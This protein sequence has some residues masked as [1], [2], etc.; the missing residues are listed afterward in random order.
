MGN[1]D[2]SQQKIVLDYNPAN[3]K[4][5]ETLIID[6]LK[7]YY[8][9]EIVR[10]GNIFLVIDLEYEK[11]RE[12]IKQQLIEKFPNI[13]LLDL[14]NVRLRIQ[15]VSKKNQYFL[16]QKKDLLKD[17]RMNEI[18]FRNNLT[19][20]VKLEQLLEQ[21]KNLLNKLE[22]SEKQEAAIKKRLELINN[23][24]S[25]IQWSKELDQQKRIQ[26]IKTN[27][28]KVLTQ[29]KDNPPVLESVDK[30]A[31]QWLKAL[32]QQQRIGQIKK[33]LAPVLDEINQLP[34]KNQTVMDQQTKRI[35]TIK[36]N[37]SNVLRDIKKFNINTLNLVN[38]YGA[39][40][41]LHQLQN[42]SIDSQ[43]VEQTIPQSM[44]QESQ[45]DLQGISQL[46]EQAQSAAQKKQAVQQLK[47]FI[48][49]SQQDTQ[50]LQ[51]IAQLFQQAQT[52]GQEQSKF[53]K[54]NP[55]CVKWEYTKKHDPFNRTNKGPV[56]NPQK[57][58]YKRVTKRCDD[59]DE[60]CDNLR[61]RKLYEKY[62]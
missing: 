52:L 59:E 40:D 19:H 32:Q 28:S 6:E 39:S 43:S 55:K 20:T 37:L 51:G 54:D 60:F 44:I 41:W 56:L 26:S 18:T 14:K 17:I 25:A 13:K 4:Q 22:N 31:Q 58:V 61:S 34:L 46:F 9:G 12:R 27:L 62:C 1:T 11:Q 48:Q 49:E 7:K 33:N 10:L 45:Q 38:D 3:I 53:Q 29:L 35:D 15:L 5:N 21:T 57:Q 47:Q 8:N 36:Q 30:G 2:S 42:A 23:E 16:H 24:I 50:D